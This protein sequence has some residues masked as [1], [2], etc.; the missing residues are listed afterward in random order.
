MT[1]PALELDRAR[2]QAA[3]ALRRLGHAVVGHEADAA[4]LLRIAELADSTA[5]GVETRTARSR[6]VEV[7]KRRLWEQPP[8]DGAPMSHFPECVVSGQANPMGVGIH[9]RRDGE[10]AV[11]AFNLGPAFE[12][13]PGRAHGGVVAAVF[14]DVMGYVLVV[15]RVPAFTGRLTVNYRAPVPLGVDLSVRAPAEPFRA[16]AVHGRR[17]DPRRRRDLRRRGPVHRD[18]ARTAGVAARRR[19]GGRRR[20]PQ[21]FVGRATAY[22]S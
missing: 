5:A 14:D 9:V 22:G 16:Q 19:R 13:A 6:P 20:A 11:A 3:A 4:L 7:M 12:G 15:H 2:E 18:P 21:Q 17:D 8:A 10:A 1:D